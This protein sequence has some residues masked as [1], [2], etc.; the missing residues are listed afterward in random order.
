M[1]LNQ[2]L[3]M[4]HVEEIDMKTTLNQ[5][6]LSHNTSIKCTQ[7]QF[8]KINL[9]YIWEWNIGKSHRIY[10][11]RFAVQYKQEDNEKQKEHHSQA[12]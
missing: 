8:V 3:F 6:Y 1:Y 5:M 2:T 9:N 4:C 7:I 10:I 12:P 11:K